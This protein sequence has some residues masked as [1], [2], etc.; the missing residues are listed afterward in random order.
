MFKLLVVDDNPTDCSGLVELVDWTGLNIHEIKTAKTA[1][2]GLDI[3]LSFLP[4]L[5]LT[6]V[7]MP[8]MDGIDMAK[9]N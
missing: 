7:S 1:G 8:V 9:R 2:E 5:I 4:D 3:A 6:D